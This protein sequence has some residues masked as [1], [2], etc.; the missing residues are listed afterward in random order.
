MNLRPTKLKIALLAGLVCAGLVACLASAEVIQRDGVRIHFDATIAPRALPRQR[1][2]P[3]RVSFAVRIAASNGK[4]PPQLRH[5][6][7]AVNRHG[8]FNLAGLP[9]CRIGEIQPATTS[10]AL[11]ACRDS[12]V[13]NGSF[14]A[15]VLLPEQAPFPSSGRIYAFNGRYQGAP[16]ILAHVYGTQPVPTSFTLAFKMRPTHGTFGTVLTASLPRVTSKWGYVT[17]IQISLERR[18]HSHGKERSYLTGNCPA[19][20][21]FPGIPSFSL[22]SGTYWFTGHRE[23]RLTVPSSCRVQG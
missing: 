5:V 4:V 18:F 6:S 23:I 9:V 13:G 19:P 14:S 15:K 16:A 17:G 7:L 20:P 22:A 8:H 12:L 1:Q 10:A 21:G 11:Q 2:A 3:L